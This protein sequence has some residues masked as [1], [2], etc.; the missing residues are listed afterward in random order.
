MQSSQLRYLDYTVSVFVLNPYLSV[1]GMGSYIKY[2]NHGLVT[3]DFVTVTELRY[4]C[5]CPGVELPTLFMTTP[6][7]LSAFTTKNSH[8]LDL[9]DCVAEGIAFT[10]EYSPSLELARCI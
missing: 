8:N 1:V 10:C 9:D 5:K 4:F 3:D 2:E 7:V 6:L